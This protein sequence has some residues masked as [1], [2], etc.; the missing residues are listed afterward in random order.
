MRHVF[1]NFESNNEREIVM[2]YVKV[3]YDAIVNFDPALVKEILTVLSHL[4]L[5]R[6]RKLA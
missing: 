3:H 5:T 2:F 1:K 4:L 6:C